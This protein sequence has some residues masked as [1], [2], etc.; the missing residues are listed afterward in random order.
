MY[1]MGTG[2]GW[3]GGNVCKTI[4]VLN[5]HKNLLDQVMLFCVKWHYQLQGAIALSAVEVTATFYSSGTCCVM[6]KRRMTEDAN[7]SGEECSYTA[8]Q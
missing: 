1:S 8:E 7:Q 3:G 2:L 6:R 5:L 4:L